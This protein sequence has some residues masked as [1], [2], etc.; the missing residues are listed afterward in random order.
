MCIK[1][2]IPEL[3]SLKNSSSIHNPLSILSKKELAKIGYPEKP[4]VEHKIARERDINAFTIVMGK[5]AKPA[6]PIS[7]QACGN[8]DYEQ[9]ETKDN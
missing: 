7:A 8:H 2:W 4:V 5:S 6:N 3:A 9:M 1:R